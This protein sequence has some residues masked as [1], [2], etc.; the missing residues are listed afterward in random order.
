MSASPSNE[1]GVDKIMA[2]EI[3]ENVARSDRHETFFLAC[4]NP[5]DLP[6][7][8]CHGWPELSFS[9]RKQLPFLAAAGFYAVAPDMRGYGRSQSYAD[10]ACFSVADIEADM[11]ELLDHIGSEKAIFVGHDW[12]TPIVWSL[13][14]HHADR[15]AGVVGICVP[16][17]PNG[18][19]LPE[20]V[21]TVERN[22]YPE[23]RFPFG[24]WD[25]WKFHRN[26]EDDCRKGL[27][28]NIENTFRALFRSG[29]PATVGS[30]SMLSMLQ[31][32]GGWFGPNGAAAPD[33]PLDENVLKPDELAVYAKAFET[34]GFAGPNAW[35]H[36]DAANA[37]H[38]AE[39]PSKVLNMPVLFVHA[40]YDPICTTLTGTIAEPMRSHCRQ[41]TETT[42][43][44]GHGV[45]QEKPD[46]LNAALETW[47]DAQDFKA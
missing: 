28:G 38:A 2:H 22:I 23:D 47:L 26:F 4:G 24:S 18:F 40:A 37:R 43:H 42:I 8:L 31:A 16:Y 10:H 29:N 12:G 13:A 19:T 25:Y 3:T 46:E 9:W 21:A 5:N 6:I 45:A 30:P 7:I 17:L 33:M 39:A 14:Q 34:T 44:S 15:V 36:N 27:E 20:L 32:V 35:Y 1:A 41:L 11:I